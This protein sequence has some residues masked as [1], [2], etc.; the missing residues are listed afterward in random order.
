MNIFLSMVLQNGGG[1][2]RQQ[3]H[4]KSLNFVSQIESTHVNLNIALFPKLK[5]PW[6]FSLYCFALMHFQA[7]L[8]GSLKGIQDI[9]KTPF[10][11]SPFLF[12]SHFSNDDQQTRPNYW[13]GCIPALDH[14]LQMNSRRYLSKKCPS[15][16]KSGSL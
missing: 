3:A 2:A 6:Y 7:K 4:P 8:W 1:G 15:P 13:Q 12:L 16:L 5:S 10:L 11:P 9:C 14:M